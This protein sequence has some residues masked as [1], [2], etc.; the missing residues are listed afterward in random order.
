MTEWMVPAAVAAGA[1]ATG[2]AVQRLVLPRLARAAARSAWKYDDVLVD[3]VRLPVV[4]AFV[5]LGLHIAVKLLAFDR[6]LDRA[7]GRAVLVLAMLTVTWALARFIVGALRTG[8]SGGTLPGVSLIANVSRVVVFAVGILVILQTL[9]ISITPIIT[10]LG[11]GGLAV[12]LALQDTLGNFF[13]GIRLL[14]SG[15]VRPGDFVQLES[16]EEGFVEDIAWGQTT[17]RQLPNNLVIV[18]NSK[19]SQAIT[20]NFSLPEAA[21]AVV[22]PVS[23]SYDSDLAHVEHVTVEVARAC[24]REVAGAVSDWE[25]FIRYN[26]F[27]DS[28]I[29]FSV[30]LRAQARPERFLL[31]HEFIKRLQA[32]YREEGIEIP[33]PIRTVHLKQDATGAG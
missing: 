33:F 9:G 23:V 5:L 29:N 15:K 26:Q 21:Q 27:G 24:Q 11:V 16:G 19:L 32:R 10:A 18:P 14:A 3:A 13:A 28:S 4:P 6:A 20:A 2:L 8:A 31:V 7:L 12:G 22:F 25:P 30:I 17:I 1:L